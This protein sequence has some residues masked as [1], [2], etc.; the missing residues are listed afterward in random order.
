MLVVKPPKVMPS[1]LQDLQFLPCFVNKPVNKVISIRDKDFVKPDY[2]D[3]EIMIDRTNNFGKW[4][5][6]N[7]LTTFLRYFLSPFTQRPIIR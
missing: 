4:F 6:V 3:R 7:I 2:S 1:Y 5:Y